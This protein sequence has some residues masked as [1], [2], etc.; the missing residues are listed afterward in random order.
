MLRS[1][2]GVAALSRS[3]KRANAPSRNDACQPFATRHR[4]PPARMEAYLGMTRFRSRRRG[5]A[6]EAEP[7]GTEHELPPQDGGGFR[8]AAAR[9]IPETQ[10][11]DRRRAPRERLEEA[12]DRVEDPERDVRRGPVL[13]EVRE[14]GPRL[15]DARPDADRPPRPSLEMDDPHRRLHHHF[16]PALPRATAEVGF[17]I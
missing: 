12:L 13:P 5:T 4:Q 9:A 2:T 8:E 1:L 15:L 16:P 3:P 17:L 7:T 6:V 10:C 14:T 11:P